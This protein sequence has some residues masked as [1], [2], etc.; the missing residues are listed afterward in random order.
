MNMR[1]FKLM[2]D[3]IGDSGGGTATAEA[4]APE[5]AAAPAAPA[6]PSLLASAKSEAPAAAAAE[7]ASKDWIPEKF[8]VMNGDALDVEASARKLAESYSGLEKRVGS[9]DVPPKT[10]EEYAV[11]VP[12]VFKEVWQ[13]DERFQAF[14][15]DAIG[16]GLTQKQFDFVVGKY[17]DAMPSLVQGALQIDAN[18]AT[19]ELRQSWKTDAEF[20]TNIGDALK[21][22][23]QFADPQDKA[24]IDAIGNNPIVLRILAKVGKEI[25]E[26][27]GIPLD[28][29]NTGADSVQDL[30][31]SD[32]YLNARHPDHKATSAKVQAFYAKKFGSTPA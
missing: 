13:E 12:E 26:G 22:F 15:A 3:A 29:A 5:A 31:R 7:P 18:K 14:K 6:A 28:S 30:M 8:R 20:K 25:Q 19:E 9:G 11:T 32:A 27:G 17:F 4:P 1:K 16:A 21:A 2:N 24:N 23:D 10:A